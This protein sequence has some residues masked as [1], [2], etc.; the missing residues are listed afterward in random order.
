MPIQILSGMDGHKK[1]D[2]LTLIDLFQKI[3]AFLDLNTW[4]NSRSTWYRT[5]SNL[6]ICT[7]LLLGIIMNTNKH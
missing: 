4:R 3:G 1:A 5:L 6:Y 2:S 7:L